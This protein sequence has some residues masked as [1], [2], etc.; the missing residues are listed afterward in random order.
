MDGESLDPT[1]GPTQPEPGGRLNT[2]PGGFHISIPAYLCEDNPAGP[3]AKSRNESAPKPQVCGD[4]ANTDEAGPIANKR[5]ESTSSA[6][7]RSPISADR[8][9]SDAASVT[10][11]GSDTR[12]RPRPGPRRRARGRRQ[13]ARQAHKQNA[14]VRRARLSSTVE[15]VPQS[16]TP[17]AAADAA[18]SHRNVTVTV[19]AS[20]NTTVSSE[21]V[22]RPTETP[23]ANNAHP[24][25]AFEHYI[26]PAV[27]ATLFC[28]LLFSLRREG[29][30]GRGGGVT[31]ANSDMLVIPSV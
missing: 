11:A 20:G 21:A 25:P 12:R 13:A 19:D 7:S 8:S 4:T 24:A 2:T 10:T 5:A 27:L 6:R 1:D 31:Y 30:R 29:G 15:A 3:T 26:E 22:D 17:D 18:S 9:V 23:G 28:Y 14:G 16:A